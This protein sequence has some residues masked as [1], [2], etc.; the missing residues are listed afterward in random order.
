MI[1]RPA[2]HTAVFF[3]CFALWTF[4]LL[5]PIPKASA[6]KVLGGEGGVHLFGKML[7]IGAYA[8][9]TVLG[10]SMPLT[11]RQL[12][13]LLTGLSFHAFATEFLQ[14]FVDRGSSL[15]DAGLDHLGIALGIAV[16]WRWWRVLFLRPSETAS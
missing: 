15:R 6:S 4:G 12:W 16:G 3:S 2:L 10:G 9:L 1:N 13:L 14:Q 7:H 8:F 11:R 5:M